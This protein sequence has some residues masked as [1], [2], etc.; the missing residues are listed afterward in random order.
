[1]PFT[2]TI[3]MAKVLNV[4]WTNPLAANT[5]YTITLTTQVKDAFMQPL[6]AAFV[7]HFTTGA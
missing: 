6:P 3:T 2:A 4:T 5:A 7:V 1:V